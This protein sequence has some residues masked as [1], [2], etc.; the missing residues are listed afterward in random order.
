MSSAKAEIIDTIAANEQVAKLSLPGRPD[1]SAKTPKRM[2]Q[3]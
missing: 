2:G 3:G 1:V